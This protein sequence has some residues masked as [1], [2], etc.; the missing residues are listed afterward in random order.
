M[1]NKL[2]R[3]RDWFTQEVS[4]ILLKLLVQESSWAAITLDCCL[5]QSQD[6]LIVLEDKDIST[7]RSLIRRYQDRNRDVPS[8]RELQ[9]VTLFNWLQFWDWKTFT[10]WSRALSQVIYYQPRYLANLGADKYND[11]CCIKLMLYYL[12]DYIKELLLVNNVV[13]SSYQEAYTACCQHYSYLDDYYTNLE[14]DP[15]KIQIDDDEDLDVKLE[16]EANTPL[17]DFEAYA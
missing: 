5:E 4:H 11:F 8:A 2:I 10:I 6:N 3:E 13:Y 1:L 15:D 7:Q 14:A 12:F 16:L 9:S 17:A